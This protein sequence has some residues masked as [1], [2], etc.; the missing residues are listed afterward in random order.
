VI[1]KLLNRL[2]IPPKNTQTQL[3]LNGDSSVNL[4]AGADSDYV[5]KATQAIKNTMLGSP[6]A[7]CVKTL[8]YLNATNAI[9]SKENAQLVATARARQQAKKGKQTLGKAR[10]LSK[11]D[12]EKLRADAEAEKAAEIAKKNSY[13]AEEERASAQKSAAGGREDREGSSTRSG[14]G[15]AR[16][17]HGD[18]SHG[19]KL[20]AFV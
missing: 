1:K 20:C 2:T 10:V 11:E 16:Y 17:Q 18:G 5:G 12:A 13:R 8:E 14:E 3:I 9:L 7:L 4:L 19:Q 6:A 15:Y